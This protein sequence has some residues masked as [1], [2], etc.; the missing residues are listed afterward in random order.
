MR[1]VSVMRDR[2]WI[3][4]GVN[5]RVE[6]GTLAAVLGP[7]GSGKSTLARVAAG[8]WWP[9]RGACEILGGKFGESNLTELRKQIRLVQPAGPYDVENSLTAREVVLTGFFG[10]LALYDKVS[11]GMLRAANRLLKWVGLT[12]VVDH[13]YSSL[14]SGERVRCLMARAM[15]SRPRL[16]ILDEPTAGLDLRAREEVLATV[17][18]LLE[19]RSPPA[20][21]LITHHVEELPPMTERVLLLHE[22]RVAAQGTPAQV[23]KKKILSKVYGVTVAVRGESG[24]YYLEVHPRAWSALLGKMKSRKKQG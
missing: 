15:A 16:L 14:S 3:L 19:M 22:G 10:T 6:A 9:T 4:R 8:H 1:D 24:R 18:L 12:R 5:W 17:Q 20:V 21:V 7:N 23:L 13:V 2:R 11:A